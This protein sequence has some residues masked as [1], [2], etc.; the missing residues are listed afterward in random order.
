MTDSRNILISWIGA[1]DLESLHSSQD[2]PIISTLKAY[3]FNQV[4]LL[5]NYPRNRVA[6]Y[7]DSIKNLLDS[8]KADVS[9][10]QYMLSSPV[11]FTDIFQ[12][13]NSELQEVNIRQ[14]DKLNILLSPGTPAMQ[15]VW[16]LLGK[17]RFPASFIQSS[18]EQGVQEV[19]IPFDIS[20]EF[21]PHQVSKQHSLESINTDV[22][23]DAAFEDI[24]TKNPVMLELKQRA[25]VLA[26]H[27]IPVLIQG[28]TGTGKELF[29]TAIH[30]AS[31]RKTKPFVP[32]NCGAIPSELM[33]SVL[34]GHKKGAFTG[35]YNDKAGVFE[36]ADGGTVFLDEFGELS[37]AAQV[38][39]LRVL[40]SGE[41]TPIGSNKTI[42]VD[43]R[44]IAAT[45]R[46][47]LEEVV[48]G[49]F[50]EDLFYRVAV[51]TL[52]LP[53]LRDREGD[54]GLLVDKLMADINQKFAATDSH[55]NISPKG[56]NILVSH[57]WQGNIRELYATLIRAFIWSKT[58]QINDND[59]QSVI[60]KMPASKES[61]LNREI[62]ESFDIHAVMAEVASHY[63]KKALNESNHNLTHAAQ[64]LGLASYQTLKGWMDKY[65]VN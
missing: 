34:F 37:K 61:V 14:S 29:A 32:V 53:A 44:V 11:D 58:N 30:N 51:G 24:V 43:V 15:A 42:H 9:C 65:Q 3:Q 18:R 38:R 54:I 39:L 56:K 7:I 21:T 8:N 27:D 33:D 62:D 59:I 17:T 22:P 20:A 49:N 31:P 40:Q 13:A 12:A 35:A 55:K 57:R 46:D 16:I 5:Y 26:K 64:K 25:T 47:L 1:N 28:E 4:H 41:I 52:N 10:T 36:Q 60:I 45:N 48:A 23:I 19:S 6:P 63:I 50:R 2:G